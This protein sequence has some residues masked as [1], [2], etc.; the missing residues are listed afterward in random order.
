MKTELIRTA[1]CQATQVL[2]VEL[3]NRLKDYGLRLAINHRVPANDGGISLG[4][5]LM[6][7]ATRPQV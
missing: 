7:T 6:A 5:A 1:R 3:E 4:R 2:L